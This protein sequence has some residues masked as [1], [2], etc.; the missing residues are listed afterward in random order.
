MIIN[1]TILFYN[2]NYISFTVHHKPKDSSSMNIYN[3]LLSKKNN[4]HH[5]NRNIKYKKREN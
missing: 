2:V 3:L 5:P 1:I 4:Q